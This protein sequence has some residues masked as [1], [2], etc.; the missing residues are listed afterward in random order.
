MIPYMCQGE[1]AFNVT[2]IAELSLC[3]DL[4][5]EEKMYWENSVK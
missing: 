2:A 5:V 1:R 3:K 4:E